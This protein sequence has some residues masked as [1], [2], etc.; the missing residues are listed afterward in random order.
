MKNKNLD[1]SYGRYVLSL[2]LL[3]FLLSIVRFLLLISLFL[4]PLL[5]DATSCVKRGNKGDELLGLGA[6]SG[7]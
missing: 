1:M 2:D 5:I 3:P 7:L 4:L 6:Q